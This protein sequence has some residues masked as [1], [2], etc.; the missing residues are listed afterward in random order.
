MEIPT[1]LG[2]QEA[3]PAQN[4]DRL[5]FTNTT[6]SKIKITSA[7]AKQTTGTLANARAN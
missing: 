1:Y 4:G 5:F 7:L 2:V 3:V 6:T